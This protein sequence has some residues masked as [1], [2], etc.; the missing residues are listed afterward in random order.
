MVALVSSFADMMQR[1]VAGSCVIFE[2]A[3]NSWRSNEYRRIECGEK[4]ENPIGRNGGCDGAAR[5]ERCCIVA[6]KSAV[7]SAFVLRLT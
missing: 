2:E 5:F 1:K 6:T 4:I 3:C 7:T